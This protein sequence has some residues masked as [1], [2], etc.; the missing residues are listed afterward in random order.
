MR[1]AM[2]HIEEY[3]GQLEALAKMAFDFY[4]DIDIARADFLEWEYFRNPAGQ[5][6]IALACSDADN[7]LAGQNIFCPIAFSA[8]GRKAMGSH[9]V[10]TLTASSFRGQG[11]SSKLVAHCLAEGKK[12][13]YAFTYGSPNHNSYALFVK[14]MN[15][16]DLGMV[17]LL[18]MPMK[19][20]QL[21]KKRIHPLL[22]AMT[23]PLKLYETG[24]KLLPGYQLYEI[25]K[26]ELHHFDDL[27][28]RLCERIPVMC[29]RDATF[30]RWRYFD[31]PFREYKIWGVQKEESIL[32][33]IV[34]RI[35]EV[36]GVRNGMIM[37]FAMAV[38]DMDAARILISNSLAYFERNDV[39]LAGALMLGHTFEYAA[40]KA[41]RFF[42]CPQAVQPQ[43]FPW[44]YYSYGDEFAEAKYKDLS[45]WFVTMGDYDML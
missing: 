36:E 32:G 21:V 24:R 7:E 31:V 9:S 33:Y 22:A 44:L 20:R 25:T 38:P 15:F 6:V 1:Q 4:G 37:D 8:F 11:I 43:P 18:I 10:N 28:A 42:K 12:R 13:K 35:A 5:T 14:K 3:N 2:W 16:A 26:D 34:L 41:A 29:V 45:N 39:E 23:P 19:I 27:S 40:L 17:P 30:M